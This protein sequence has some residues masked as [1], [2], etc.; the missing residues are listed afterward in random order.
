MSAQGCR[1]GHSRAWPTFGAA[2]LAALIIAVPLPVSASEKADGKVTAEEAVR[3]VAT[4]LRYKASPNSHLVVDRTERREGRDYHVLQGY[5]LI[6][7]DPVNQTGHTATW[8]WFFVDTE[9]GEAF[10]WDLVEDKLAEIEPM[11]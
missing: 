7:T 4:K 10:R 1:R 3:I 9:T 6:I 5:N 8:G 2:L 11:P